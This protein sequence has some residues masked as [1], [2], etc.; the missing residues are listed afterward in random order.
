[1]KT[2]HGSVTGKIIEGDCGNEELEVVGELESD[3]ESSPKHF[4]I[5]FQPS[6]YQ[7][8][9]LSKAAQKAL[10]SMLASSMHITIS[11][12]KRPRK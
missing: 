9:S 5:R 1:M 7:F 3:E 2:Y 12:T 4:T 11:T 8:S 10:K 6:P